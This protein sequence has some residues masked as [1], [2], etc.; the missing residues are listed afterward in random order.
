[1]MKFSKLYYEHDCLWNHRTDK[2]R[3][4]YAREN[5]LESIVKEMWISG[6]TIADLKNKIK[7]SRIIYKKFRNQ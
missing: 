7:T 1:M 2:D 4:K 5:A 3:N 6:L